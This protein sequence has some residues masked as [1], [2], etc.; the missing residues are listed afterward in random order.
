MPSVAVIEDEP[1]LLEMV[2]ELL[3]DGGYTMLAIID[4]ENALDILEHA[5]PDLLLVDIMLQGKSGIDIVRELRADSYA[6]TPMIGMSA[7]PSMASFARQTGLFQDIVEKPFDIDL[8]L[9]TIDRYVHP[10]A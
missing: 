2:E 9:N 7:S 10:D 4:P 8:L 1:H 3:E 5:H 6:N